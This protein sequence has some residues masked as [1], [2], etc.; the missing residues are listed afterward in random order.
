MFLSFS[1]RSK[2]V[3]DIDKLTFMPYAQQGTEKREK[4]F[5]KHYKL[6]VCYYKRIDNADTEDVSVLCAIMLAD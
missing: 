4:A 3:N 2:L 5:R 6:K 1:F